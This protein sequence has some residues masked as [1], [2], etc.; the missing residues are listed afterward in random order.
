MLKHACE[1]WRE[2]YVELGP[3]LQC[4][5]MKI[6]GFTWPNNIIYLT[7]KTQLIHWHLFMEVH[8]LIG[9]TIFKKPHQV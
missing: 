9:K 3:M 8:L 2:I 5:L 1:P 4:G 6:I 7:K